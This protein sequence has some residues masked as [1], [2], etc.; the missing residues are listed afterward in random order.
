MIL[1][2]SCISLASP[3][4]GDGCG[5]VIGVGGGGVSSMQTAA[6]FAAPVPRMMAV[7]P[8]DC[9]AEIIVEGGV[10]VVVVTSWSGREYSVDCMPGTLLRAPDMSSVQALQVIGTEKV[11]WYAGHAFVVSIFLVSEL[12]LKA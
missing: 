7:R 6:L 9:M 11:A 12:R 10:V 4:T 3:L 1:S 8:V 2:E 5:S